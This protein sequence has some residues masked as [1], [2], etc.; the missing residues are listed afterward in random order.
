MN[1]R[2]KPGPRK[3]DADKRRVTIPCVVS[4]ET[5]ALLRKAAGEHSTPAIKIDS[6]AKSLNQD[7]R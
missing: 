4:P 6:L 5:A 3:M 1:T 7:Q 2:R